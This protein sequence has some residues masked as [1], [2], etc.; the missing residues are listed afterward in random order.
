MTS[1]IDLEVVIINSFKPTATSES[2]I[3]FIGFDF[4]NILQLIF[5]IGILISGGVFLYRIL[6]NKIAK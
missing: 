4:S 6:K 3:V 2:S 5:L 1:N